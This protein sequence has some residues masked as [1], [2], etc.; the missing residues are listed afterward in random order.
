MRCKILSNSAAF[1]RWFARK[2]CFCGEKKRARLESNHR[3]GVRKIHEAKFSALVLISSTVLDMRKQ[4]DWE[5]VWRQMI[6]S[7]KFYSTLWRF[8][9]FCNLRQCFTQLMDLV[10]NEIRQSQLILNFSS[11]NPHGMHKNVSDGKNTKNMI[12][13]NNCLSHQRDKQ[14]FNP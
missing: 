13:L 4:H 5:C 1:K 10:Y 14:L 9:A 11:L 8:T 6:C 12:D 7:F 2:T 3:K